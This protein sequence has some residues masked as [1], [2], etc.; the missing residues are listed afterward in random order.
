MAIPVPNS[1]GSANQEINDLARLRAAHA[2]EG[3]ALN[4]RHLNR[5]LGRVLQTLGF[6]REWV[7]G[8][9]PYLID[10]AGDRYLDLY[11]GFGVFGLGRSFSSLRK[12]AAARPGRTSRYRRSRRRAG[13]SSG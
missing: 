5:Q 3:L 7:R 9:G 11:A 2:G 12:P 6:D 10:S 4:Q 8:E 13:A 1:N